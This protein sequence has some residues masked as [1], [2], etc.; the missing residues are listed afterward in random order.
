MKVVFKTGLA[1]AA[2]A[3][4]ACASSVIA[5][6]LG[7]YQGSAPAYA[8]SIKD[9]GYAAPSYAARGPAGPCYF[10][11]DIGYSHSNKP[12]VSWPVSAD[13]KTITTN[14]ATGN[15][16]TTDSSTYLGDSVT[17]TS[18]A[19]AWFGGVGLGCGMGSHGIRGE[20]MIDFRG[21]RKIAGEP[22]TYT[23][24]VTNVTVGVP[25]P[26]P[27]PTAVTDPLHSSIKTTTLMFN[28]YKDLGNFN[29][30]TPYVGAGVGV[31]YNQMSE[32]Y[33]TGNVA[34]P[35][36]I[37]GDSRVSLAWS[38]M[39]GIGWQVSDRAILDFGYRYIDMG[40]A[41]SGRVDT[42][43]FANPRV[44]VNDISAHEVKLGLRYHFGGV[45]E[46]VAYAPMK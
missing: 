44:L 15:V 14:A 43:N 26:A 5:A 16:T 24:T 39:A 23:N 22:L 2:L 4:T 45:A 27:V 9:G 30:I 3:M 38:L 13:A 10:R 36:R 20:A 28:A 8:G 32:T 40:K 6:D 42:A 31:A 17:G 33:F 18:M 35:N 25:P 12:D 34:L 21:W 19:N 11:G 37:E 41:Q 29:G 46:Q 7:G 1:T